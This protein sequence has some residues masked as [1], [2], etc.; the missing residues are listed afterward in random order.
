MLTRQSHGGAGLRSGANG[1]RIVVALGRKALNGHSNESTPLELTP[2]IAKVVD[3]L[4]PICLAG[5]QVVITHGNGPQAGW[6]AMQSS[7]TPDT[8]YSFEGVN[9]ENIGMVCYLI[10]RHLANALPRHMSFAALLTQ[11]RV[12]RNDPSFLRPSVPVGPHYGESEARA[13]SAERGWRVAPQADGWRRVVAAP[14]PREVLEAR[15][16]A[17]LLERDVIVVCTGGGGVTVTEL[18]DGS[19]VGVEA[20]VENDAASALLARQIEADWLLLL[21]DVDGVHEDWGRASSRRIVRITSSELASLA[22]PD[23]SMGGK[24]GAACT[25]VNETGRRAAIGRLADAEAMLEGAAG[26]IICASLQS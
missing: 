22:V 14:Q 16:V 23:A 6:L 20:V 21:T 2:A 10:E 13:L 1:M 12:D 11:I 3:A 19:F 5:H 8:P 4:A 25:F 24:V 17:M 15:I 9:A 7:A 26:T 18:E